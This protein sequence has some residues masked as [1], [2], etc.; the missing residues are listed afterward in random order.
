MIRARFRRRAAAAAVDAALGC[1]VCLLFA[2][3][4][5]VFFARQAFVTL[6]IGQPGTWWTG[7]VPLVLGMFGEV[8]YFL[9]FALFLAWLLDPL[10]GATLGKRLLGIRVRA[11]NGTEASLG[12]RFTRTVVETVGLW[13]WTVAILLGSWQLVVLAFASGSVVLAGTLLALGRP[14]LT[15]HDRLTGTCVYRNPRNQ[16]TDCQ[17]M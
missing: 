13:G 1:A 9:P 12:R 5:G 11:A 7:P 6:R 10:S 8:V 16:R 14:G 3:S 15:L 17:I 2:K 4:A